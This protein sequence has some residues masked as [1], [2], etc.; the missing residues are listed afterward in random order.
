KFAASITGGGLLI[1]QNTHSLKIDTGA[2]GLNIAGS[3]QVGSFAA[4]VGV[5]Y[6]ATPDGSYD[7]D[8]KGTVSL[9]QGILVNATFNMLHGQLNSIGLYYGN[10]LNPLNRPEE[11]NFQPKPIGTT[12]FFLTELGGSIE[13]LADPKHLV[14]KGSIGVVFGKQLLGQYLCS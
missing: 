12:G 8:I 1:D 5:R 6:K 7:L 2:D 13:N 10:P 9:P 11:P 4:T 3:L 14:V